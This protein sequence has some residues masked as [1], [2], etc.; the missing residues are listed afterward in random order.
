MP[1]QPTDP[2][3]PP[4]VHDRAQKPPGVLPR[5]AQMVALG[6]IALVM[7]IV[8]AFSGRSSPPKRSDA[9]TPSA[10]PVIDPS[11]AR[12]QEYRARIEE[13]ARKLAAEQVQLAQTQRG[14]DADGAA[15]RGVG[16]ELAGR[17]SSAVLGTTEGIGEDTSAARRQQAA[18]A[19]D[20]V[21]RDYQS[22]FATNVALSYR[23][24]SPEPASA[25][26]PATDSV[27]TPIAAVDA[28]RTDESRPPRSD[29]HR[30]PEETRYPLF[31]GTVLETVLTNRLDGSFS[32]PVNCLVTTNVYARDHR[33]LLVPR[34]TRVLGEVKK[35]E[36]FGEQ[37]LAVSFHRLILP[38]GESV[39]LDKVPGLDQ[40]GQTGLR[41]QVDHHYAQVF[42]VSL[43]IGAIAGLS[44]A[45]TR[46]GSDASATDAY[47]QGVATSL[48]QTSLHILDRY[49]NVLP[50]FTIR[51][52][53][54]VKVYLTGDLLLPA[55]RSH[56]DGGDQ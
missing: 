37:R 17:S 50:T 30:R 31:E 32:G 34:G 9:M 5:N 40:I 15:H 51:E 23:K 1:D 4:A 53:Q 8:I 28:E 33:T 2:Y 42:G 43:A 22:R 26:T 38:N 56:H 55:Y 47:R 20:K 41:D 49:L 52:G 10:S 13:Q 16:D 11:A 45:N 46:Y 54:R 21:Q 39:R 25:G 3:V 27:A 24:S 7:V 36:S 19:A 12:I 48:S 29:G 14:F 44:Q 6:S 18:I 35:V